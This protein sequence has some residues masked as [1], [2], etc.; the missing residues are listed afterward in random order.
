M[1]ENLYCIHGSIHGICILSHKISKQASQL[2]T[3]DNI[4]VYMYVPTPTYT[5]NMQYVAEC[6]TCTVVGFQFINTSA[7]T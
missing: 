4:T 2:F 7:Y 3:S 6:L 1:A 5:S